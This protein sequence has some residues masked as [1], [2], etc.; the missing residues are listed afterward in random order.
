M[1]HF[2]S[3]FFRTSTLCTLLFIGLIFGGFISFCVE[4]ALHPSS[5]P[6][7]PP[8]CDSL[9]VLTGGEHRITT[10]LHLFRRHSSLYLLISGVAPH[11]QL[12]QIISPNISSLD[13]A[14]MGHITLGYRAISTV[15]NARETKEWADL[16]NLHHIIL[17]TSNYHMQRA[18][19]EFRYIAPNLDIIPYPV[20]A[21]SLSHFWAYRTWSILMREYTKLLGAFLRRIIHAPEHPYDLTP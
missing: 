6:A 3:W 17:I 2:I 16:H 19:L 9:V 11:S 8:H 13:P 12:H 5:P 14:S 20:R 18:L 7:L 10:A 4:T 1:T 21:E 15:G